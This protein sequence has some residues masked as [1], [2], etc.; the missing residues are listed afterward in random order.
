MPYQSGLSDNS[1]SAGLRQADNNDVRANQNDP[2]TWNVVTA[3]NFRQPPS[4]KGGL[5]RYFRML[6]LLL[7][8]HALAPSS[9][10]DAHARSR[11]PANPPDTP[12]TDLESR[13]YLRIAGMLP[14]RIKAVQPPPDL[15][16]KPAAGAPP[17]PLTREDSLS[18][19]GNPTI[20][21]V[22]TTSDT[23]PA[24]PVSAPRPATSGKQPLPILP[25][26]THP[27]TRPEDFLPFFQFPGA[28]HDMTIVVPATI[29]RPPE[30]GQLPP[31]SA[32]YQQK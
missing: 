32:T 1:A 9:S 25:D 27:T 18:T 5:H 7:L 11:L 13:P 15:V 2:T 17:Q 24:H 31:S 16:S 28:N 22:N 4:P 29:I 12:L 3:M 23:I 30:P 19:P 8:Q 26:D 6:S 10:I 21:P 14:L 20:E